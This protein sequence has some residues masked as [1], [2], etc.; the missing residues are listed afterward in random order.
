MSSYAPL[1][2][3]DVN[4]AIISEI[5]AQ[6]VFAPIDKLKKSALLELAIVTMALL[7]LSM[8]FAKKISSPLV[9]LTKAVRSLGKGD[10][11]QQL[12]ITSKDEIGELQQFF[13]KT[14][15]ELAEMTKSLHFH[16]NES[17]SLK[18]EIHKVVELSSIDNLTGCYNRKKINETLEVALKEV[19]QTNSQVSLLMFDL[20]NFKSV[21]DTHGHD[22]GDEVLKTVCA[23]VNQHH[24]EDDIFAPGGAVMS[25]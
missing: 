15:K 5:D 18:K 9:Q 6:E 11:H 25:L 24:R 3:P 8:L 16:A 1:D 20:D 2:I 23:I 21:N 22:V 17:E 10:F 4:W 19:N 12:K 13:N 14:S 7:L